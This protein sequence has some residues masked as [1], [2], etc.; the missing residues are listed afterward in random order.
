MDEQYKWVLV[1][2]LNTFHAARQ[3]GLVDEIEATKKNSHTRI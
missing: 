1:F 2:L 3:E